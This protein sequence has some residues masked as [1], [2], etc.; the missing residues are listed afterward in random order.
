MP[1][2]VVLVDADVPVLAHTAYVV[3]V[4]PEEPEVAKY[5]S[6]KAICVQKEFVT[7]SQAKS[8][9]LT[10]PYEPPPSLLEYPPPINCVPGLQLTDSPVESH[11]FTVTF[12]RGVTPVDD[13][14][15]A[16]AVIVLPDEPER[17]AQPS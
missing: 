8:G 12:E 14:Q 5:S 17:H 9:V 1:V 15:I 7:E 4:V 13:R 16:Y 10:Q 6:C 3:K 11:F 2:L